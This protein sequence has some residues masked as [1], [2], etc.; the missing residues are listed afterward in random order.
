MNGWFINDFFNVCSG[1]IVDSMGQKVKYY[2]EVPE[3]L[4]QLKSE[5]YLIA[6]ASRTGEVRGAE[7]LINLFGWSA[8]I[9]C[10]HNYSG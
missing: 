9:D 4:E 2:P 1:V 5:G 6:I 8:Y 10:K 7:S 3:I